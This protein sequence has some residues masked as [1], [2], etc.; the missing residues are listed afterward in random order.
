MI[1]GTMRVIVMINVMTM[2]KR[3]KRLKRLMKMMN[4]MKRLMKMMKRMKRLM[5][6]MNRMKRAKR[7]M[8]KRNL[9]SVGFLTEIVRLARRWEFR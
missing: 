8:M 7:L 1:L 3:M 5:K 6:T 4:R 2:R 9:E